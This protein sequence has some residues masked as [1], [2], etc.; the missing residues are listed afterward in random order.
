MKKALL[1]VSLVVLGLGAFAP[2]LCAE[3]LFPPLP[4]H[5]LDERAFVR[6]WVVLGPFPNPEVD[7]VFA[8]GSSHLE[9]LLLA[10]EAGLLSLPGAS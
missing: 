8:D 10:I 9:R 5:E 7:E 1:A 6:E 4:V 2:C 3:G